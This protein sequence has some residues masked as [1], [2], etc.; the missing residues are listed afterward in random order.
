ML[1]GLIKSNQTCFWIVSIEAYTGFFIILVDLS[2]YPPNTSF[3]V[4]NTR[5]KLKVAT[6]YC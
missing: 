2:D 1:V 3:N 4:F 5:I 6:L